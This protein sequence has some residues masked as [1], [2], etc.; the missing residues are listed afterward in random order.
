V[1]NKKP[2]P[3]DID[4][5]GAPSVLS[6]AATERPPDWVQNPG[7]VD[8]AAPRVILYH[9]TS[10]YHLTAILEEGFISKGDV[11]LTPNGGY[12]SPWLTSDP[13]WNQQGWIGDMPIR[14]NEV[15]LRVE[16]PE[17]HPCLHHWPELAEQEGVEPAWMTAL[18]AP[19]AGM[20]N[21]PE[22]WY[23]FKGR[24]PMSWVTQTDKKYEGGV[25]PG[26]WGLGSGQTR[27]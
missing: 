14:K 8:P 17:G 26:A 21:C 18:T 22:H 3:I 9:F 27:E 23:V 4:I 25:P 5:P 19:T 10:R 11:P 13:R 24:I 16:V 1:G 7:P 15:R 12:N 2:Y 20:G 6:M